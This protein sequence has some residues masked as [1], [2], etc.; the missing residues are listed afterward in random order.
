MITLSFQENHYKWVD[1]N[2]L[3]YSEWYDPSKDPSITSVLKKMIYLNP[4]PIR[5]GFSYCT[6]MFPYHPDENSNWIKI[7]CNYPIEEASFICKT[8]P[9]F[10]MSSHTFLTSTSGYL[11]NN[12]LVKPLFACPTKWTYVNGTCLRLITSPF[13]LNRPFSWK[14]ASHYCNVYGGKMHPKAN[15]HLLGA[16]QL[17]SLLQ[18]WRHLEMY[19][20]IWLFGPSRNH[21]NS[22]AKKSV[23][24]CPIIFSGYND[25]GDLRYIW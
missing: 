16:A 23:Y 9:P 2:P 5:D 22:K 20:L 4:Q 14:A 25:K 12:T 1:G 19:G 3:V 18:K 11:E 7:P 21:N 15:G 13:P 17:S 10:N 24:Y 6:I 8:D